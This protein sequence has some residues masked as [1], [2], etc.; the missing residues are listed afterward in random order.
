LQTAD[1]WGAIEEPKQKRKR[2]Q[3]EAS[4]AK[5]TGKLVRKLLEADEDGLEELK[6]YKFPLD[7]DGPAQDDELQE[8]LTTE[9]E[10]AFKSAKAEL[11]KTFGKPVRTGVDDHENI[12]LNGVFRFAI[13]QVQAKLLWL[14]AAHE[15]RELPYVLILGTGQS[16]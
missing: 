6:V 15:D 7:D 9:F 10:S 8:K 16:K 13:W 5:R 12:P 14:A 1:D 11:A 4:V 3:P 2:R